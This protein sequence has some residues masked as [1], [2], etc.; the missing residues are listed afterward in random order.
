MTLKKI[1]VV[2]GILLFSLSSFAQ[3]NTELCKPSEEIVFAF[4]LKNLKWV[5]ICKE[6]NEKYLVYRFGTKQKIE[7]QYPA[8]TDSASWQK[9]SFQ[10]YSRGGGKENAAMNFAYLS[11]N[12]QD[13]DYDIYEMWNSGDD[14][15]KCGITVKKGNKTADMKGNLKSR[16]GYLLSLRDN[17][18]IKIEE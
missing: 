1:I 4:Q 8:E 12:N 15:E 5:S 9:F 7:L 17:D 13:T 18:K 16:K 14:Q 6:K 2:A 3:L 11:F 10:G